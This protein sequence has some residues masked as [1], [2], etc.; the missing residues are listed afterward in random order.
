M[1]PL[2]IGSGI[3]KYATKVTA[4]GVTYDY[5]VPMSIFAVFGVIAIIVAVILKRADKTENY[6]LE[7]PNIE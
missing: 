2:L 3:E 7:K 5:T 6:G 4:E 1:V